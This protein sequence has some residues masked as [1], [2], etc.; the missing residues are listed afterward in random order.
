MKRGVLLAGMLTLAG[1]VS[2]AGAVMAS[3][4]AD[5]DPYDSENA[6]NPGQNGGVGFTSWVALEVGSPGSMYLEDMAPLDGSRSWGVGGTYALGRGLEEAAAEGT[7]TFL[8]THGAT[9]GSFCGFSLRTTTNADSFSSGEILRFGMDY[10]QEGDATRIYCSTDGGGAY[11]HL[12]L[13]EADLRG[14]LLTYGVTWSTLAGTFTL[15]VWNQADDS[16]AEISGA[17]A[18]GSPVAMFGVGI[19]EPGLDE[20]MTFDAFERASIPEPGVAALVGL[21]ALALMGVRWLRGSR[22]P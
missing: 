19:F 16:H 13:G 8:A 2:A 22:S 20:R 6:F 21:G 4:N 10:S 12:D 15:G 17:L 11:S 18:A 7:W 5:N 9:V 3:D 14:S 1:A